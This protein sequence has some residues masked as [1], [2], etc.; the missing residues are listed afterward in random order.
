[1]TFF[2]FLTRLLYSSNFFSTLAA[3][4]VRVRV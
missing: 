1:M 4:D 2:I 3:T